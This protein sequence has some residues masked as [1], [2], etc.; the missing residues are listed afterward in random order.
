[1]SRLTDVIREIYTADAF[2]ADTV[3]VGDGYVTVRRGGHTA[4]ANLKDARDHNDIDVLM[5]A[6]RTELDTLVART[7]D[8]LP[9]VDAA[10]YYGL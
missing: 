10:T 6:L 4:C 2:G 8:C 1:M 5:R 3:Y 9:S 7:P